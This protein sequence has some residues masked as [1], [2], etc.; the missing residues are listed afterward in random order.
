VSE[1][2]LFV[3]SYQN[4]RYQQKLAGRRIAILELPS[5]SVSIGILA[6]QRTGLEIDL[7]AYDVIAEAKPSGTNA[8]LALSL[9]NGC[10]LFN[11]M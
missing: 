8:I 9:S 4:I 5:Y 10:Q 3:T 2:D 6:P 1:F 11:A 7:L